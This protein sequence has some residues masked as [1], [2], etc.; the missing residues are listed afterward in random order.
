[1]RQVFGVEITGVKKAPCQRLTWWLEL[2]QKV[3]YA[4]IR[5][6]KGIKVGRILDLISI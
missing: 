3:I 5:D 6:I 2:M 4:R 1:M